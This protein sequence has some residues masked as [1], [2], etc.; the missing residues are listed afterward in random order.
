MAAM[1][2]AR[3]ARDETAKCV[4]GSAPYFGWLRGGTSALHIEGRTTSIMSASR[5]RHHLSSV[6]SPVVQGGSNEKVA[7]THPR[8][9][10]NGPDLGGRMGARRCADRGGQHSPAW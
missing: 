3:R 1:A 4:M 2:R 6:E 5:R 7:E 8:C 9:G 10:R